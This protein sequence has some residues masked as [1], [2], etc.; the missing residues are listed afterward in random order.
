MKSQQEKEFNSLMSEYDQEIEKLAKV[1]SEEVEIPAS[2][3]FEQLDR[4]AENIT[5]IRS[6]KEPTYEYVNKPSHYD[7]V[8]TTVEEMIEKQFTHDELMGWFKGN[9]MK[10]R[11]RAFRKSKNGIIDIEKADEYQKFYDQYKERNNGVRKKS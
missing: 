3:L 10:Y 7:I 1:S 9:I 2:V 6:H 5:Q 8:D 4:E 11:L